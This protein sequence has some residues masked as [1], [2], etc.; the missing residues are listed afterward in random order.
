MFPVIIAGAGTTATGNKAHG[1]QKSR[2]KNRRSQKSP[3]WMMKRLSRTGALTHPGSPVEVVGGSHRN[4]L[5][6]SGPT[7]S[8]AS[9]GGWPACDK[10][11]KFRSFL[12]FYTETFQRFPVIITCQFAL[13]VSHQFIPNTQTAFSFQYEIFQHINEQCKSSYGYSHQTID[14]WNVTDLQQIFLERPWTR[15]CILPVSL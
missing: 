2:R 14:T 12:I 9:D 4:G 10:I 13:V 8:T 11:W 6:R 1:L 7:I 3:G 5:L 15:P